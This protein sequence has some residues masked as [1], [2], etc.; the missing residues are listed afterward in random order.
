MAHD[1]SKTD[2]TPFEIAQGRG[3]IVNADLAPILTNVHV[4][5]DA[6][7]GCFRLRQFF[8]RVLKARCEHAK[9]R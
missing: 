8:I 2:K 6:F 9:Q 7:V 4:L 5:R 3:R 1:F